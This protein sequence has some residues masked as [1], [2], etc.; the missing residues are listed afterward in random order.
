[1]VLWAALAS[2]RFD[3]LPIAALAQ[4][5]DGVEQGS[6][7]DHHHHPR[8]LCGMKEPAH[9]EHWRELRARAAYSASPAGDGCRVHIPVTKSHDPQLIASFFRRNNC[10]VVN[11]A[12]GAFVYPPYTGDSNTERSDFSLLDRTLEPGSLALKLAA[13]TVTLYAKLTATG[14]AYSLETK[15]IAVACG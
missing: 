4:A 3:A 8:K 10:T 12:A 2:L 9:C 6:G 11:E 14:Q 7:E 5:G 1:M 13:D 15:E